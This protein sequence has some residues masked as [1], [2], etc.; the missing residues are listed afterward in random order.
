MY[1]SL[2]LVLG[3]LQTGSPD[4]FSVQT[5]LQGLY[6]EISQTSLQL[7]NENELDDFHDVLFAPD[8]VLVDAAGQRRTWTQVRQD[9]VQSLNSSHHDP[10][11]QSIQKLTLMSGGATALVNVTIIRSVIDDDGRYGQKGAPHTLTETTPFRDTWISAGDR[12][13]FK[14]R[15]QTGPPKVLVDKPEYEP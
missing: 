1:T 14:S 2:L 12:W 3:L 15:Q 11:V 8:W 13:K 6:D 9:A 4:A 10:M 7:V 5:E